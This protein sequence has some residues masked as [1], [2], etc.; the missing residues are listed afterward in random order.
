MTCKP[1]LDLNWIGCLARP[2]KTETDICGWPNEQNGNWNSNQLVF[3]R[4]A[5]VQMTLSLSLYINVIHEEVGN[6]CTIY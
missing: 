4:I 3:A 6:K 1:F 5:F 2:S